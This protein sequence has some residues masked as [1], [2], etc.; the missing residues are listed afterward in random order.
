[1]QLSEKKNKKTAKKELGG[2]SWP[3]LPQLGHCS[4]LDTL[5]SC[6]Q[7][8]GS[9]C[10][11]PGMVGPS[12]CSLSPL[13]LV[14]KPVRPADTSSPVWLLSFPFS[15][16]TALLPGLSTKAQRKKSKNESNHEG[17]P[18]WDGTGTPDGVF[19]WCISPPA[20][21]AIPASTACSAVLEL[22]EP[23]WALEA[24]FHQWP[25]VQTLYAGVL[26]LSA[27]CL[28]SAF[29]FSFSRPYQWGRSTCTTTGRA[30][31][32]GTAAG[33]LSQLLGFH[34]C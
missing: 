8:L 28:C 31:L 17:K 2:P 30:E 13:W 11:F 9:T 16:A 33:K 34:C 20:L 26:M 7:S 23:L 29:I 21:P 32:D 4:A 5:V 3:P 10:Y 1:M 27:L 19:P 25:R 15:L 18:E 12:A 6:N 24:C 14:L 22:V